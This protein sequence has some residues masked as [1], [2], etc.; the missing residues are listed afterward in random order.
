MTNIPLI[1]LDPQFNYAR[2]K[3]LSIPEKPLPELSN[4]ILSNIFQYFSCTELLRLS[5]VAQSNRNN[6]N[7]I[8]SS[9]YI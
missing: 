2:R 5:T 4:K 7:N 3:S 8:H 9:R 6:N 1:P